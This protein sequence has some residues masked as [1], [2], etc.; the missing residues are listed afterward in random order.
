MD[1]FR[2]ST[3]QSGRLV[4][5]LVRLEGSA[6]GGYV[7]D[8][9]DLTKK[10]TV[11]LLIDGVSSRVVT[12]DLEM[13]A[14]SQ[15][16]D[17]R[18]G[19]VFQIERAHWAAAGSIEVRLANVGVVIGT[20]LRAT[21]AETSSER[22][23]GPGLATWLGGLTVSG[24]LND[25]AGARE[26]VAFVNGR[27]VARATPDRWAAVDANHEHFKQPSFLLQLPRRFAD[28]RVHVVSVQN[29]RGDELLGS[30]ISIV[31]FA[32]GLAELLASS[33]NGSGEFLRGKLYDQLIP[34]AVPFDMF[35]EWS[36]RFPIPE[37]YRTTP[38]QPVGV[39]LI[40][41][42]PSQTCMEGLQAQ[43]DVGWIACAIPELEGRATFSP[44]ALRE[45]LD[46][47]AQG[48]EIIVFA[49]AE[50]TFLKH[51]LLSFASVLSK[52]EG[53]DTVYADLCLLDQDGKLWPLALP[54]FDYERLLEQGY[55]ALTFAMRRATVLACIERGAN[56]L[57]RL[58]SAS[59]EMSPDRRP[60][61]APVFLTALPAL[62]TAA[63]AETLASATAEHL[64][65]MGYDTD[66]FIDEGVLLPTIHVLRR[67]DRERVSILIPTRDRIDLLQPCIASLS[68]SQTS[69][70]A[71]IIIIDN[72]SAD[73]T[74]HAFFD[75]LR[76]QGVQIVRCEGHFNFSRLINRGAEAASGKYLCLLNNDIE[77][78]TSDWLGEMQSRMQGPLV[79]A[80]GALLLRKSGLIQHA[81]VLLG[82][83]LGAT[84]AFLDR[85][86]G[87]SGYTDLLNVAHETSAV[88]GA[89]LLTSRERFDEVAG[90]DEVNFA[91]N[92]NDVDFCL[93]LRAAGYR[94]I[95]T[96]RAVLLHH[97]SASRGR[98]L[99]SGNAPN[100][101]REMTRLQMRW[102]EVLV[103]DPFYNPTLSLN[104]VPYSGLAWPPRN[105]MPRR[106]DIPPPVSLP[107]GAV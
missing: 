19:F 15:V 31:A 62:D 38:D 34:N 77:A 75:K 49:L 84:H 97:E 73:P 86:Y 41:E 11:E 60:R 80:V 69:R 94:I 33:P 67:S 23:L 39:V 25:A 104:G 79:G 105:R 92:F 12:A 87:D 46:G 70:E 74:T 43:S 18:F 76:R 81:G 72:D 89:C 42:E 91:I 68:Q 107:R 100:L 85:V 56:S 5:K 66:V 54:A 27:E 82:P 57:F 50:I 96:P 98:E 17:G 63:L 55:C 29:A 102:R 103:D 9:Q 36:A 24:W 20:P 30:P 37:Y 45:F 7:Y 14:L 95:L 61:H 21:S 48:C 65:V 99:A 4:S 52:E 47:D 8:P 6:V 44:E 2:V 32:D 22:L 83:Y 1:V 58:L 90:L 78:P 106:P 71:E 53:A 35:S 59:L 40:G 93:K 64:D 51:A 3:P 88:T 13:A 28:G 10:L 101:E 26:V 16:G